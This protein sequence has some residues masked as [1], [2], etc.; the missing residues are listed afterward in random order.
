MVV[1]SL[2]LIVGNLDVEQ[3]LLLAQASL[4]QR[5][6][7]FV[8]QILRHFIESCLMKWPLI[9]EYTHFLAYTSGLQVHFWGPKTAGFHWKNIK[10]K[11]MH[12]QMFSKGNRQAFDL[13]SLQSASS[14]IHIYCNSKS[15]YNFTS[16][17][18]HK[19]SCLQSTC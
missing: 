6:S 13:T 8:K 17:W 3:N 10:Q 2:L 16:S 19:I 12:T 4:Q 11:Y 18:L 14:N 5:R 1:W 9:Q 7:A 15:R